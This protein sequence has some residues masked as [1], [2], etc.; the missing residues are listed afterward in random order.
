MRLALAT[1]VRRI[2]DMTGVD[3]TLLMAICFL[4]GW[5]LKGRMAS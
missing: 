2:S 3:L 4:V 1:S 5:I